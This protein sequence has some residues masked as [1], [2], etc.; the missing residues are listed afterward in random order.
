MEGG[1][2]LPLEKD[3]IVDSTP[4][5]ALST[6]VSAPL[7]QDVELSVVIPV[8]N[9]QEILP[10]LHRRLTESL[11]TL[12][13][14]Y[15]VVLV[16]DGSR[17]ESPRLMAE[18]CARDK[19]FRAIHF[20]RNFGHQAAVTAGIDHAAGKAVV[21]MDADL[22]DPP[23]VLP[24]LIAK[25]REGYEV[26][27]GVRRKR[28]EGPLKRLAYFTFYRLLKRMTAVDIPLDAGDFALIDRRVADMLKALPERNRFVR[29]LRSWVGFRQIGVEYERDARFAGEV[30]YTFS[31][32]MRLALDGMISFSYVPLRLAV[33]LGLLVSGA[34]FLVALYIIWLKLTIG[35]DLKG[36]A[37]T[38]VIML[39]LG[40]VQLL[41]IGFI[42]EYVS[43]I[44]DEVKQRPVYV[45]R[46]RQGFEP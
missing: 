8:Y 2:S 6:R 19:A 45:V 21:V 36:W 46:E 43:R 32:L 30:K 1:V 7:A 35:I 4:L 13:L 33:Y 11:G 9:E 41:T 15:E 18:I 34:S 10:E 14:S 16:N 3:F 17:D 42:G 22:Q 27:Y 44:Y 12:G 31:K 38:S 39:F 40:G 5:T 24:E 37:S 26:V 28:K 20:S 29:G 23:E 25:W